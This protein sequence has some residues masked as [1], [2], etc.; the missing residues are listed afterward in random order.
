MRFIRQSSKLHALQETEFQDGNESL[1]GMSIPARIKLT[2]TQ[3]SV[4]LKQQNQAK[5]NFVGC[6]S[7]LQAGVTKRDKAMLDLLLF[8]GTLKVTG[9]GWNALAQSLKASDMVGQDVIIFEGTVRKDAIGNLDSLTH[10]FGIGSHFYTISPSMPINILA[11]RL[12]N[13]NYTQKLG[14]P[15]I[16]VRLKMM[17]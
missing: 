3:P 1:H 17:I 12:S 6:G 2:L 8:V 15:N 11:L 4:L 5:V 10:F 7:A 14:V 9:T 16:T 13:S